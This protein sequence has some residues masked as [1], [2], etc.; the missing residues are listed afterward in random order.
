[1]DQKL[2]FLINREWTSPA[3]DLLMATL[4]SFDLWIP[5]LLL[6]IACVAVRGGFKARAL[7]LTAVAVV[8]ISDALVANSLKH[9]VN[10][11]RPTQ[12]E[13]VRMVDF[14]KA[15]PRFLAFLRPLS[16]KSSQPE[17]EV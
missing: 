3:L 8:G 14:Q 5:F 15:Q 2:F 9:A 16:V 13:A 11:P 10:R 7:L 4:S 6:L 12:L 17:A 1:M